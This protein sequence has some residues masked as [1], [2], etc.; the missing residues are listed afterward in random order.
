M[1]GSAPRPP[2]GPAD[3]ARNARETGALYVH[4]QSESG[5]EHRTFVISPSRARLLRTLW[6]PWGLALALAVGGSWVYFA[7]QSSR[8]PQLT[9]HVSELE[10][11]ALRIDTLQ[12]R[13]QAPAVGILD[14]NR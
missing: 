1:T 5:T 12:A 2:R 3:Q 10:A 4:L 8:V 11:E 6:S 14:S 9:R 7:V 13:L